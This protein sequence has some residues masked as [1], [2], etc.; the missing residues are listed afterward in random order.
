[1][2]VFREIGASNHTA[3]ERQPLDYYATESK[4]TEYLVKLESLDKNIWEC[5]CGGGHMSEVLIRHGHNVRCS[6]IYN[7]GGNEILDFLTSNEKF[8]G[9]IVSNPPYKHS[10][11]FVKKALESIPE[12][13]KVCMFLKVTFL[14][15]KERGDFFKEN[16]PCRVWVSSSRL[17]C[18]MNGDFE[19]LGSSAT[20]YAWF[21]WIKGYKGET[22]VKWFN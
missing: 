18:A 15:G 13:K 9:D 8:D 20:A 19:N 3:H 12:G 10:L 17:K 11:A 1:M 7:Y 6:D 16:P 5:A 21:V 14:E 22:I 2:G 4:A